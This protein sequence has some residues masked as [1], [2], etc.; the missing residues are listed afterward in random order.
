VCRNVNNAVL[1][2]ILPAKRQGLAHARTSEQEQHDEAAE[3]LRNRFDPN[4]ISNPFGK[5]GSPFSPTSVNNPFGKYGSPFSAESATNPYATQAPKIVNPYL[6]RLS[7][8]PYAPDSIS[9]AFGPYGSPFS[10]TSINNPFSPYWSPFS[11]SSV[12]NPY[13]LIPIAPL[14]SLPPLRSFPY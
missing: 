12:T 7:A 9:N 6:G 4:S 8:N 1:G 3:L 13:G 2:D 14:S 5:Y 11:P 10:P